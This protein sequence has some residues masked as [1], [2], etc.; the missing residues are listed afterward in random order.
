[1]PPAE[2]K[3]RRGVAALKPRCSACGRSVARGHK[4]CPRCGAAV[5]PATSATAGSGPSLQV[6]GRAVEDL[7][8][9]RR[10]VTVLFADLSGST[11]LGERLDPEELR[12]VLASFFSALSRQLQAFGATIDKY[13]GDA[14]MA[15]FG[16]PVAHEDDAERS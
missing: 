3:T 2:G 15:V 8:E 11:T 10:Q 12:L 5:L 1:M 7:A 6:P 16:A 13:I 4:Y 9:E 14:V